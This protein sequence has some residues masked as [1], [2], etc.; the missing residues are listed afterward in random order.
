MSLH[1][2]N[3]YAKRAPDALAV[4]D[5]E[6][7]HWS[8]GEL[9]RTANRLSRALRGTGLSS[10]DV[11]AI[12]APNCFEYLAVYLAGTQIGLYVVPI[13]WHL[14]P[15]EIQYILENCDARALFVHARFASTMAQAL[16]PMQSRPRVLIA[17][18]AISG[19][20]TLES[21]T[22]GVSADPVTDAQEGRP[23]LYTSATTGRPK[24]VVLPLADAERVLD[25]SI[26]G[27][28]ELGSLPERHVYLCV[29]MLY[30]GAPLDM[31]VVAAHMGNPVVLLDATCGPELV[32]QMIE[33]YSVTQAYM[34]PTM[35]S[36]LLSLDPAVRARYSL[37]SLRRVVHGGGPCSPEVKRRMIEWLGPILWEVYG[38]TEGAGA[39]VD[40]TDWLK[41]PGTVGRAI[42][43]TKIKI[44]DDDG[45]E[46]PP[47]VIGT[48]Y[49]T[50]WM[51]DRF[52]YLGDPEKTRACHRGDFFTAG[53]LGYVNQE[54]FLF[55]S[56]RK[57]DLII[58]SGTKVY[59]A[60]VESILAA[61]PKV[62]DCAV[63]GVPDAFMGEAVMALVQPSPA[64]AVERGLR[65]ELL[66]HVAQRLSPAMVPRYLILTETLPREPTGKIQK[67]RLRD[68]YWQDGHLTSTSRQSG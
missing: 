57:V 7:R 63:F 28:I 8:R 20:E 66:R 47:G 2:V 21:F 16:Q 52:H 39:A 35:F 64:A 25:E 36:R 4:V 17:H 58:C 31:M 33:K 29:S 9:A 15:P 19:F 48:I 56:D 43:G 1:R 13:N 67:R 30:H 61:H 5:P 24:G 34:V 3:T 23:L 55:I 65:L 40:S 44:L 22:D 53:D 51:G 42:R 59:P 11:L 32:L 46:V 26:Q 54:G 60:E 27:R 37:P 6:Q 10:G 62:V 14:A 45:N 41:F 18:G 12:V 68:L 49:M 50:R 38:A